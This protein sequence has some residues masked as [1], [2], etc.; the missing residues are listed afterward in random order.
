MD[1]F[2]EIKTDL[3]DALK[4]Q[5]FERCRQ[6]NVPWVVVTSRT[7]FADVLWDYIS[8]PSGFEALFNQNEAGLKAVLQ[9]IYDKY[10]NKNSNFSISCSAILFTELSIENA[11]AAA[12]EIFDFIDAL[13]KKKA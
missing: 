7:K 4:N 1:K 5:W 6:K 11:K 2:I 13:M 8:Y 10:K 3:N 12:G 9:T